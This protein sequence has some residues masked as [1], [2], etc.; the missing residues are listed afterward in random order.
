MNKIATYR[1]E[2]SFNITGRG[3]VAIGQLIEGFI[4]IGATTKIGFEKN[5]FT[6]QI[7][8]C[9]L[10]IRTKDNAP[11]SGLLLDFDDTA[12]KAE[13]ANKKLKEQI[14]DIYN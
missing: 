6:A 9:D 11:L 12:I 13:I 7:L 4:K 8:D 3:I 10:S 5:F 14:I 1:I 2:T